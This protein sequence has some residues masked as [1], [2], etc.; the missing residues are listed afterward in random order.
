MER[1]VDNCAHC[2]DYGCEKLVQFFG[3]VPEARTTLDGIRAQL[4]L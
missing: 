3:F 1:G 4:N 2:D